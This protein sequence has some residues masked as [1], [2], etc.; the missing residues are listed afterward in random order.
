MESFLLER[1]HIIFIAAAAAAFGALIVFGLFNPLQRSEGD[2]DD[3]GSEV[4]KVREGET[5][6]VRYSSSVVKLLQDL[7]DNNE[8]EVRVSSELQVVNFAGLNGE[9]RYPEMTIKWIEKGNQEEISEDDFKTIEYRFLPDKGNST[10][11]V[12]E[13]V[14]YIAKATNA[15]LL[16]AVKPLSTAKVGDKYTVELLM[17]TGG[18]VSYAISDKIIEIVP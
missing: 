18:A 11:Y 5:A 14:D 3:T 4:I 8:V 6:F 15:Q 13:D 10:S 7:P 1:Q 16:V 9:V 2:A 17:H 12:Y